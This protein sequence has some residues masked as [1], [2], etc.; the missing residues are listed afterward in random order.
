MRKLSLHKTITLLLALVT[1]TLLSCSSSSSTD[2]NQPA[3]TRP[4]MGF[5]F[6]PGVLLSPDAN[7]YLTIYPNHADLMLLHFG[8]S[9]PWE[10][11]TRCADLENCALADNDLEAARLALLE[12]LNQLALHATN[13]PGKV[14]LSVSPLNNDRDG[15]ATNWESEAN[16][17]FTPPG[18]DFADDDIRALYRAWVSFLVAKF[19]P[20]YL[21]QGIEINM[22]LNAN[23]SDF[24]NLLSLMKDVKNDITGG[25]QVIGPTIQWEFYKR[26]WDNLSGCCPAQKAQLFTMISDWSDYGVGYAFSTYP[27]LFQTIAIN[28]D[29]TTY[30]FSIGSAP[31][32]IAE[33]GANPTQQETLLTRLFA[34][35]D[36]YNLQ[37]VLWFFLEDDEAFFSGLPDT[38]PYT[39]FKNNGLLMDNGTPKASY[40]QW[41]DKFACEL[42]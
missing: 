15:V 10:L 8:D 33:S 7:N 3:C 21:S 11:L 23:T 24:A 25:P 14:Y 9:V 16:L 1:A 26:G 40:Q 5:A 19:N 28:Y 13:F 22:Y 27:G 35:K 20:D 2:D 18:D 17:G 39:V 12:L 6:Y 30:G 38:Y 32:F 34:I 4:L 37:G 36:D 41:L 31:V 42:K 29:F